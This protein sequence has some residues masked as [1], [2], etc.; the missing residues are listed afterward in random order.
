VNPVEWDLYNPSPSIL[1]E[2][3]KNAGLESLEDH[4]IGPFDLTVSTRVSDG[5]T[6][7]P[8]AVSITKVQELLVG[9]VGSMVGDDIVR[10]SKPIDDVEEE[11]YRLFRADVGDG[12]R[13]DPL[14]ELVHR[15]E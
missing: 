3:V 11:L 4:A 5:G 7:D 13:L 1:F 12:L 15:H 9:E 8:D 2:S 14:G 6:I 10:N